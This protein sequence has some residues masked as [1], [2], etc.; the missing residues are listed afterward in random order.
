MI[1]LWQVP[2]KSS[3]ARYRAAVARVFEMEKE[4]EALL[5]PQDG[6]RAGGEGRIGTLACLPESD[7]HSSGDLTGG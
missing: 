2:G 6:D 7:Q 4:Q 1:A 5:G 3:N